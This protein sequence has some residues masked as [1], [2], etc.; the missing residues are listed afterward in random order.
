VAGLATGQAVVINPSLDWGDDPSR[1]GPGWR[2]L[3]LP[4]NGTYAQLIRVPASNVFA[5]PDTLSWEE[6]AA[7]P[8]AGLTAFRAVVTRAQVRPGETVLI[9]G[10]GGGVSTFVLSIAHHLARTRSSSQGATRS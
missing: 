3:G 5:K 8:L 7:I 1:Q 2:I 6:A 9:T 10:A 4:D